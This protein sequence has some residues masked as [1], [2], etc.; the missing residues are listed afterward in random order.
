MR[1]TPLHAVGDSH[2][3]VFWDLV[4]KSQVHW[5]GPM[6][7]YRVGRDGFQGLS[8]AREWLDVRGTLAPPG[9]VSR[10]LSG[11]VVAWV[12]GEIDVRCHLAERVA[13]AGDQAIATLVRSYLNTVAAFS[14]V[15]G[16]RAAVVSVTPAVDT[17]NPAFPCR[18][19]LAER[20]RITV[21]L[22][23]ELRRACPGAGAAFVDVYPAVA[24]EAGG[25]RRGMAP[26]TLHMGPAAVPHLR[27]ALCHALGVGYAP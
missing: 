10:V 12:F 6:L 9:W 17:S 22:N 20:R 14:V 19:S 4:G 1:E 16:T 23:D 3:R 18:G 11:S 5:L 13:A 25:F 21:A 26:D 2:S 24:D 15:T 8:D 7:M 27:Q